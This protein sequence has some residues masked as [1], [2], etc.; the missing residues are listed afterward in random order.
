MSG[1]P[2]AVSLSSIAP[3]D[4]CSPA[5]RRPARTARSRRG[6][7]GSRRASARTASR[8]AR[9][10]RSARA[11]S[12]SLRLAERLLEVRARAAAARSA[13]R[14]RASA[15]RGTPRSGRPCRRSGRARGA[16]AP[17]TARHARERAD[18]RADV[19][20]A[21]RVVRL[22]REQ[23]ARVR[24]ARSSV[25]SWKPSRPSEK[26]PGSPPT[27]FSAVEPEVAVERRVL[28]ALRHHGAGRLL[29]AH[30]ELVVRRRALLEQQHASQVLGQAAPTRAVRL[31]RR[32]RVAGS[33]YV[34]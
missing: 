10:A 13:T 14:R 25:A 32:G 29:P 4:A 31:R 2:G 24:S 21:L 17:P 8:A 33:T 30:D 27:S 3:S 23:L 20:G 5:A 19:A 16:R 9:A 1:S 18:P 28:H 15:R 22:R 34:R 6:T 26:R 7:P 11:S 12:C